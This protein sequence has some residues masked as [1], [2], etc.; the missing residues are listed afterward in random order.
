MGEALSGRGQK[1]SQGATVWQEVLG[2]DLGSGA[3]G[4]P[5]LELGTQ[6]SDLPV[7]QLVTSGSSSLC[8][9]LGPFAVM[10]EASM[11][12]DLPGCDCPYSGCSAWL[13]GSQHSHK[14]CQRSHF[15]PVLSHGTWLFEVPTPPA[16]WCM[17]QLSAAPGTLPLCL[18]HVS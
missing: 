9:N 2:S 3:G 17:T 5:W 4:K 16:L 10:P 11:R 8:L 18:S 15:L 1:F 7:I 13:L 6:V 12:H 14:L